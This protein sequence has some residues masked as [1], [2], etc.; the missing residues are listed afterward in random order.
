M[1]TPVWEGGI[2]SLSFSPDGAT[3]AS[4]GGEW[5]AKEWDETVKLWDVATRQE[6]A[7]FAFARKEESSGIRDLSFSPDGTLLATGGK[8]GSDGNWDGVVWLWGRGD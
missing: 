2:Y 6:I 1:L 4:G 8:K 5:G 3:L 7:R